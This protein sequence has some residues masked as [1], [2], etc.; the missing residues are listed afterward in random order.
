MHISWLNFVHRWTVALISPKVMF[1]LSWVGGSTGR[2]PS[3]SRPLSSCIPLLPP[4]CYSILASSR[5]LRAA[6]AG[7]TFSSKVSRI[8]CASEA[9][10]WSLICCCCSRVSSSFF[11]ISSKV[12]LDSINSRLASFSAVAHSDGVGRRDACGVSGSPFPNPGF[13]RPP[14]YSQ[15]VVGPGQGGF[16]DGL[17]ESPGE[18]PIAGLVC[19]ASGSD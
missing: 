3:A 14:H 6:P 18:G 10:T 1:S 4:R 5:Q 9:H 15:V 12:S 8:F 19:V 7:P 13:L 11:A 16:T 2:I 17:G